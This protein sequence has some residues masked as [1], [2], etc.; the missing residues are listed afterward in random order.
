MKK[1]VLLALVV[2]LVVF[3]AV[4]ASAASLD[5]T[6]GII[7]A[8]NDT[9]LRCDT[10]GVYVA[11]WGLEADTGLVNRVRIAGVDPACAGAELF[12]RVQLAGG[13][14]T[15]L[16][17]LITTATEYSFNFAPTPAEN[18][19]GIYVFIEGAD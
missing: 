10:D 19:T 3:G 15:D 5:V 4:Y 13:A 2:A 6:G 9:D 17:A 11:G 7:Q 1:R 8:G 18:I 12:A 16:D 14:I